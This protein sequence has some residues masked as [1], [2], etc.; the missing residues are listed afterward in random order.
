MVNKTLWSKHSS[1]RLINYVT[2]TYM[3]FLYMHRNENEKME[4][5]YFPGTDTLPTNERIVCFYSTKLIYSA[6]WS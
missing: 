2:H 6:I 1:L 3:I 4:T 5:R